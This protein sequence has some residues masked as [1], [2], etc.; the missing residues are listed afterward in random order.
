MNLVLKR[1]ACRKDGIYSEL[2]DE[3]GAH[4]AAALEH[5]YANPDG[6]FSPKIPPGAY[7]CLRGAHIL[8]G[9]VEPFTTFE[10]VGVQGHSGLLFHWGNYN[11]DSDGCVLVG[12][13]IGNNMITESRLKFASFM[14][15]QTMI[16]QF[17]LK[18]EV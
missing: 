1:L 5:A 18:V 10:I 15:L 11:Q 9:M 6:T 3:S 14:A 13:A 2:T 7:R 4:V 8:H 17:V 16:D 12:Q